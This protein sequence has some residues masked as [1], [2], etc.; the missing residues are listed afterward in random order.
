MHILAGSQDI[1]AGFA[2]VETAIPAGFRGP[3][4]HA[5]DEFDEAIYVLHGRLVVVGEK[6]GESAEMVRGSMFTAPR[7]QRHG[8]SN[9]FPEDAVVLGIWAPAAPALAFMCDVG[10]VLSADTPPDR[11]QMRACYTRHASRMLP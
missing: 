9:P 5:H 7:G 11:E 4:P 2:S 10:A 1:P 3:V 6:D 8:F